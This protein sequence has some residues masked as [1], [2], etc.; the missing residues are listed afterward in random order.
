MITIGLVFLFGVATYAAVCNGE[1][2][3]AAMG[4]VV[5]L[6]VL[7]ARSSIRRDLDAWNN[8]QEYWARGG[9][10]RYRRR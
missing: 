7:G 10:D 5:I 6:L 8:R 2:G 3:P 9:P 4:I 1:W